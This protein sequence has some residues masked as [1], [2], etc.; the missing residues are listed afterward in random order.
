MVGAEDVDFCDLAFCQTRV[1]IL[2]NLNCIV[3]EVHANIDMS[4]PLSASQDMMIRPFN[5]RCPVLEQA[6]GLAESH[7]IELAERNLQH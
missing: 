7:V 2:K 5:T 3:G 4:G 6:V 1:A